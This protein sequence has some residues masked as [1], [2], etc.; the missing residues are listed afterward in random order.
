[1]VTHRR[2]TTKVASSR[3][4]QTK[5]LFALPNNCLQ[6]MCTYIYNRCISKS[7]GIS[8]D[9]F[10]DSL[11]SVLTLF[12]TCFCFYVTILSIT[13]K[14]LKWTWILGA[15]VELQEL[16]YCD[17]YLPVH[18][19]VPVLLGCWPQPGLDILLHWWVWD[20]Y[21]LFWAPIW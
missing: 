15:L 18:P 2:T 1:M 4:G 11:T 3:L 19:P 17:L 10:I 14:S 5:G 9:R 8:F 7:Q 6:C 13:L 20:F 12:F 21:A 16:V